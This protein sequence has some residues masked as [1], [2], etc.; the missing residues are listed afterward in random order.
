[1]KDIRLK[2]LEFRRE[3]ERDWRNL[4]E[5]ID[6]ADRIGLHRMS[7][8]EVASLPVY[9]RGVLSSL[10]VARSISLDVNLLTYL[11]NLANRAFIRVYGVRHRLREA[12]IRFLALRFPREVRTFRWLLVLATS[13]FLLGLGMGFFQTLAD[14]DNYYQFV[15]QDM[16]QGRDPSATAEELRSFL[17]DEDA[18]IWGGLAHFTSFLFTHNT[19]I[20]I[21]SF[22]LGIAFGIPVFYILFVNGQSLGALAALYHQHG[23]ST[24]FWGWVLPHGITEIGALLLCGTAG[25]VLARALILPGPNTRTSALARQGRRAGMIIMGCV[26]MLACAALI[27]GLFRQLVHSTGIRYAVAGLTLILW[28]A[29]FTLVGR[30]RS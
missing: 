5:L 29:Y 7:A 19:Q 9:Y 18:T 24:E 14:A 22:A 16:A 27:E 23:L 6:K 28:T 4:E 17:F 30:R 15:G 10:S 26:V 13:F 12:F 25:L 1:M 20:G 11:D 8:R 21:L 2:S 3:R